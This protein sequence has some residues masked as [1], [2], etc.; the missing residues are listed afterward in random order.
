MSYCFDIFSANPLYYHVK[1]VM[2]DF[3]VVFE[4]YDTVFE[5]PGLNKLQYFKIRNKKRTNIRPESQT[6][7]VKP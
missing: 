6:S 2:I 1:I 3:L 7:S 4:T 5:I